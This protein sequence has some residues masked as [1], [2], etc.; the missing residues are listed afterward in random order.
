MNILGMTIDFVEWFQSF[1]NEFLDFFFNMISFLGE[2]YIFIALM[3][4]VYWTYDK[5]FGEFLGLT[6]AITVVVNNILKE[7]FDAP[8]PFTEYPDRVDNLRPSTSSGNSFP[9]G[10]TQL[11]ST[12]HYGVAFYLKK[13]WIFVVVSVL[14]VLMMISRVYL[15]VH[16]LEDVLVAGLIGLVL[17]YVI[18]YYYDK[19]YQNQVLLHR[20]YIALILIALPTTLILGSEDLF[21]GFGILVGIILAVMY[22]KKYVNF[23]LDTSIFNKT[24]RL[25]LGIVI[26]IS[27]QIGLKE[28]Y[29]PFLDEGTYLFD[30]LS[31]IRYFLLTFIGIGIYPKAF[32]KFNF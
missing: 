4:F 8:R 1:Q 20:I 23:S 28:L 25:V 22:E 24:I 31:S 5:K 18:Y 30:V 2:E 13:K 9:S 27:L 10:H 3:G 6:L 14:V 7:I 12:F 19:I 15:G 29:S 21:K 32:K 11:F 16:Y 17:G 26:M